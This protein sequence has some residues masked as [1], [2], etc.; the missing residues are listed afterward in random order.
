MQPNKFGVG[1]PVRRQEDDALLRGDGRYVADYAPPGLLHAVVVRSPHTHARFRIA[2]VAKARAMPGVALVLTG[3]DTAELGHLPCLG[4]VPGTSIKV[5]PYPVLATDE[6]RHVGDAVAFVV[7]DKVEQAKDAAEAIAIDWEPLPHVIGAQAALAAGAVP[8]WPGQAGNLVFDTSLGDASAT[9]QAFARAARTVSLTVVNQRLVTNYLDTRGV[10]AEVDQGTGR[11][12][13]TLG[14]QGGHLIRDILCT[15]I[16][17]IA[18]AQM[19]VITPD[20]G[21]GFGTKAFCYREY[22]LAAVAAKRL[23]R[24]VKWIADRNEHFL[25]DAQGRDNI[26]TAR[27]ALDADGRFSRSRSISSPTWGLISRATRPSS[28]MSAP[29]CRPGSMTSRPVMSACAAP[30]PTPCRSTP[31]GAPAG[32]R[33]AISS[34]GWSMWR[35]A[36]SASRP[37]SCAG[38]TSSRRRRCPTRPRPARPTTPAISPA[39]WRARRSWAIGRASGTGTRPRMRAGVCAASG[40]PPI[41]RPAAAAVRKPRSRGSIPTAASPC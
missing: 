24:P 27:L 20:V 13:L 33:R 28:L 16:L 18:P 31:I 6:V 37:T 39:T 35:R 40:S 2:D 10:I 29:A 22:A 30:T 38:G 14:S 25:G 9:A 1:Q 32:R 26:T 12:T 8:V 4:L 17:R 5:P 23:A 34:S 36:R 15:D 21:G 41:S 11:L 19:R 7:A 3:A